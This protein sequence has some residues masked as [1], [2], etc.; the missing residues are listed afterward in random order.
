MTKAKLFLISLIALVAFSCL[1]F[2]MLTAMTQNIEEKETVRGLPVL[3]DPMLV[4]RKKDRVLELYDGRTFIKSYTIVLGFAP[5]GD[6][7][8]EGDGRTPE[9]EF[10][11]FTKNPQSRFHLSL[12]LSYPSTDDAKRGLARGI[13]SRRVHDAIVSAITDKKMPPQNTALGGEVYIHGGGV[14]SDWTWGCPA[15]DNEDVE[16]IYNAVSVGTHVTILP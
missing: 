13:I 6:K 10:F 16:E 7:E 12:G 3:R 15:L 11:V 9:G 14:A 2:F 5:A 1:A 4:I 8:K